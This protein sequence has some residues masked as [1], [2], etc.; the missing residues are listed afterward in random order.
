MSQYKHNN[1]ISNEPLTSCRNDGG[2]KY[3][4]YFIHELKLMMTPFLKSMGTVISS[5]S[6][7]PIQGVVI[8]FVGSSTNVPQHIVED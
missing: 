4:V 1:T 5:D 2:K 7:S 8:D 6:S 3:L